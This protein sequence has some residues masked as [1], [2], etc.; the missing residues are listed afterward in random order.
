[1]QRAVFL[2][3]HKNSHATSG[4]SDGLDDGAKDVGCAVVAQGLAT[5]SA[6]LPRAEEVN[7]WSADSSAPR[8]Q[9]SI[10]GFIL[11]QRGVMRSP[12]C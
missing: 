2:V 5:F 11:G 7:L 9:S 6:S 3:Y 8:T 12:H 10:E 4:K 1:M